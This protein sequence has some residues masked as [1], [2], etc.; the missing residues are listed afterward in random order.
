MDIE[1]EANKVI[2][3]TTNFLKSI[4][5]YF[6]DFLETDFHKRRVP[7]RSVKLKGNGLLLGVATD[8]YPTFDKEVW[9]ALSRKFD[10]NG[11]I[12]IQKGQ[13]KANVPENLMELI[14]KRIDTLSKD[15]IETVTQELINSIENYGTALKDEYSKARD[16]LENDLS[17]VIEEKITN[18][19]TE[20]IEKSLILL[21]TA[22]ENT[23]YEIKTALT[24]LFINNTMPAVETILQQYIVGEKIDLE[25]LVRPILTTKIAKSLLTD[26]FDDLSSNDLFQE[27]AEIEGNRLILDKQE[28]YLYLCDISF[29]N[30]KYPLFYIPV[31][32][33]RTPNQ[34]NLTFDTKIYINKKAIEFIAQEVGNDDKS[35]SGN[36]IDFDRIMYLTAFENNDAFSARLLEIV[37]HLIVFFD[38]R[39]EVNLA[40]KNSVA[41]NSKVKLTNSAYLSLFD[42]S[43]EA[44]IN[45][46]EQILDL[47]ISSELFELFE[48]IV[49]GFI[50][51]EP[52]DVSRAIEKDWDDKESTEKLSFESP[53]PLNGEQQQIIEALNKD[54]CKFITVE[55]PPGTGKSHTITALVFNAILKNQSVLVLSDKKEALDVVEEKIGDT[56]DK[57]RFGADFKNPILRLGGINNFRQ[58]LSTQAIENIKLSYKLT[59]KKLDQLESSISTNLEETKEQIRNEIEAYSKLDKS[60]LNEL[61]NLEFELEPILKKFDI[62]EMMQIEDMD[63]VF[64]EIRKSF[65]IILSSFQ[66][67]SETLSSIETLDLIKN[68][69][70]ILLPI[71]NLASFA[72]MMQKLAEHITSV[73]EELIKQNWL[74][75]FEKFP[76]ISDKQIPEM[77]DY[78]SKFNELKQPI[79]GFAFNK[80][81]LIDL[82]NRF[83]DKFGTNFIEPSKNIPQIKIAFN[84]F[85]Q[86]LILKKDLPISGKI[87]ERIDYL[88]LLNKSLKPKVLD[89]MISMGN[90]KQEFDY[91]SQTAELMPINLDSFNK[92]D[93]QKASELPIF[94]I[95]DTDAQRIMRWIH[96]LN[97]I[98]I[99]V[100][101][102]PFYSY[103]QYMETI[104]KQ[105][106]LRMAQILDGR[107]VD[108]YT[109]NR[110]TAT[111]V[112]DIIKSKQ[113]FPKE[114]FTKLKEAFPCI[115]AGIRD[116]ADYIPLEAGIFDLVIIDEASQVSVAQAFPAL[117]RGKKVVVMG[118]R[119]QFGNVKSYQAKT[120]INAE[121]QNRL[122]ENFAKTVSSDLASLK[123]IERLDV[124]KSILDFAEYISNYQIMLKKHFRSYPENISFSNKYFYQNALQ[125]MKI[126]GKKIGDVLKFKVIE[127]DGKQEPRP[128]TNLPEAE[129]IINE[130]KKMAEKNDTSSTI[131]IITPHTN[132]QRYIFELIRADPN[133][134]FYLNKLKIKVMTFDTCQGEERD[135]IYY[136]MVATGT[137]DKLNHIFPSDIRQTSYENDSNSEI[138]RQRLN[139]GFSRSKETM[140]FVLSKPV[141]S[142]TGS[143]GEAIRHYSNLKAE[144]S[145]RLTAEAT[146]QNSP[147]EKKVL[148]WI[149]ETAF[150]QKNGQAGNCELHAQFELGQY[151]AQLDP[152]YH[153][154]NYVVDFILFYQDEK[155]RQYKIIFEYDGLIHHTEEET[156]QYVNGDNFE[157]YLKE[158]DVYRMHVL[159]SYGYEFIR[160]HRFNTT[161]EP[162]QYIN[163]RIEEL[164]NG[165]MIANS[166]GH[167][168]DAI[169]RGQANGLFSGELKECQSCGNVIPISEFKDS[170]LRSGIGRVCKNCKDKK[171]LLK[172]PKKD[173]KPKEFLTGQ[174]CPRCGRKMFLRNGRYGQFYGCS[175]FPYCKHTQPAVSI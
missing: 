140:Y 168:I 136:S 68:E 40:A 160:L 81:K 15:S 1:T 128:N 120:E 52:V 158:E 162:V 21:E 9:M 98:E 117:I 175:G 26:Y 153:H 166:A 28:L 102:V 60:E 174:P 169:I 38:L 78:I 88:A 96:L 112:K 82:I 6:M 51:Q 108:F 91:I 99:L 115:L 48:A 8:K 127:H 142:Y 95:D 159:E 146:D 124:K 56:L 58:I 83:N 4:A 161:T 25:K 27:V 79:I 151:L 36:P 167:D 148:N 63:I 39:G 100:N 34:L 152:T 50:T 13:Y 46:Y 125:V 19:L 170:T 75:I 104:Q 137:D 123:K 24:E 32:V 114:T 73:N 42:K 164:I 116:Y 10:N 14:K 118:D 94:A 80:T 55:G 165:S 41:R 59:G 29:Q 87:K 89:A 45:D 132:Q 86:L 97:S 105:V 122:R 149:Y 171:A 134:D 74:G 107:V 133:Y 85:S 141:E 47:D 103:Q 67:D 144:V 126:R 106:T 22:D 43:D 77:A 61:E 66:L 129:F 31:E 5:R 143:I 2:P 3:K 17:I 16:N 33:S 7:R 156:R 101:D 157:A 135:T 173:K 138:R 130:L 62:N 18:P 121:Y 76:K 20:S 12:S 71:D 44:L 53:V 35:V 113:K 92:L 109:D 30:A 154:P 163:N 11:T 119:L 23:A 69:K 110:A 37:N 111:V 93:L 72:S 49:N 155:N 65:D 90:I 64:D 131:G 84:V 139:V 57:V 150:W 145:K 70:L 172:A 54:E 147:M